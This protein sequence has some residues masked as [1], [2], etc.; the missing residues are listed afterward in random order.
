MFGASPQ[1]L[2]S[3]EWLPAFWRNGSPRCSKP[4][5]HRSSTRC[6]QR[7][8]QIV[9]MPTRSRNMPEARELLSLVRFSSAQ[10][11]EHQLARRFGMATHN[12]SSGGRKARWC[13][14]ISFG[15]HW[16]QVSVE[17][18]LKLLPS[19]KRCTPGW[20]GPVSIRGRPGRRTKVAFAHRAT[21]IRES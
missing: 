7:R 20:R 13:N 6:R 17:E 9:T 8:V 2:P 11:S 19:R 21:K 4:N 12:K 5:V 16:V 3:P 15:F 14:D 1:H 18:V 10:P